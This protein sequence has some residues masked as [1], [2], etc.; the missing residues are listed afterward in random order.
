MKRKSRNTKQKEILQE[1]V[2]KKSSFFTAEDLWKSVVKQDKNL[3]IATVYRFLKELVRKGK[4]HPYSC[5]RRTLYSRERKSHCHF[6]C[7]K[8]GKVIHF[9]IDNLNFLKNIRNKI[10]GNISSVQLEIRGVCE[11]CGKE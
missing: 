7:E 6:I 5:D 8:T 2:L 3:G 10:P 4:I 1:E 11:S 9:E